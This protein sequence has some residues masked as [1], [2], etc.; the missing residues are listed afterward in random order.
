VWFD[1]TGTI[2]ARAGDTQGN[3]I[4]VTYDRSQSSRGL[5]QTV[6]PSQFLPNFISA[7][8][9]LR[10]T[11]LGVRAIELNDL[12]LQEVEVLTTNGPTIYFS[13]QFPADEYS[14][15]IQKLMLQSNFDKLQYVDCRTEHRLF[16]K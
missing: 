4:F 13:L 11:G 3:L 15:V 1:N 14:P 2:F 6:L 8:D 5:N 12:S 16:Y 10:G 7:I 9:V